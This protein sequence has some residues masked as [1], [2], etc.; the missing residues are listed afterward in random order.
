MTRALPV[1]WD[2]LPLYASD[3]A[4][5]EAVLGRDRR[6]E[7]HGLATLHERHG[8]PKISTVWGGRYVPGVKA[9][10]DFQNGLSPAVPLAPDGVEGNF[11]GSKRTGEKH[12]IEVSKETNRAAGPVLVRR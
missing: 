1:T 3:E 10:L 12:R 4:I 5:G 8:M 7:F 9:Y 6:G 11:H 2:M